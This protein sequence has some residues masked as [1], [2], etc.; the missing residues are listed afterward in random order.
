MLVFFAAIELLGTKRCWG[1]SWGGVA[2]GTLLGVPDFAG[3][4]DK[5]AGD[6]R[7]CW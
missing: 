4:G 1:L 6:A 7:S 2:S 5:V 3:L